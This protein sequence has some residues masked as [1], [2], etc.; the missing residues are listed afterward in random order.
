MLDERR[1]V[2]AER[3]WAPSPQCGPP[4][5]AGNPCLAT[6]ELGAEQA[7]RLAINAGNPNA[8]HGLA[9]MRAEQRIRWV[10]GPVT[11]YLPEI[12]EENADHGAAE[13]LLRFG[14]DANGKIAA[15]WSIDNLDR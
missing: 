7:F 5:S 10:F 4:Y 3:T 6:G 2:L 1:Q 11:H 14:L 13:R 9:E 15:P 12:Q 8:Q